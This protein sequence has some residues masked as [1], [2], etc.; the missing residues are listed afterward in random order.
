M[1]SEQFNYNIINDMTDL[2]LETPG[3]YSITVNLK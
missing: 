3:I 2:K 1:K